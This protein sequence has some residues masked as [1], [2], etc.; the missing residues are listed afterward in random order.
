MRIQ[1]LLFLLLASVAQAVTP[2]AAGVS[3]LFMQHVVHIDT[4]V[5]FGERIC[6]DRSAAATFSAV[7]ISRGFCVV[8]PGERI[9]PVSVG[10]RVA[11]VTGTVGNCQLCV[12]VDGSTQTDTCVTIGPDVNMGTLG[13]HTLTTVPSLTWIEEGVDYRFEFIDDAGNNCISGGSDVNIVHSEW[14]LELERW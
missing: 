2:G 7:T 9:R 3:S 1:I 8:P 12:N 6:A 4:G 13:Q 11:V 5:Q 10:A 14:V